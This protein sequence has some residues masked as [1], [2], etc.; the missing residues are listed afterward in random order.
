MRGIERRYYTLATDGD[1]GSA[2]GV[3]VLTFFIAP[4]RRH[5]TSLLGVSAQVQ[6]MGL[7]ASDSMPYS[8][9]LFGQRCGGGGDSSWCECLGRRWNDRY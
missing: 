6:G 2:F 8:Q 1:T 9:S 5:V 3:C 7:P 4:L